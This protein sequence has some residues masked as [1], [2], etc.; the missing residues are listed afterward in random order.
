MMEPS[1]QAERLF[2]GRLS[3]VLF[4]VGPLVFF[5]LVA[6]HDIPAMLF[7]VLAE[8]MA[9]VC[10]VLGR[11]S[12]TGKI[13]IVGLCVLLAWSSVTYICFRSVSARMEQRHNELKDINSHR[14]P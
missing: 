8:L 10:G 1:A 4:V 3:L 13:A 7:L 5:A 12:L 11:K 14:R 6:L 9:M 2:L